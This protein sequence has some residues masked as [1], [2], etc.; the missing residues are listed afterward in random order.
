MSLPLSPRRARLLLKNASQVVTVGGG[1]KP[2]LGAAM[3][4]L[5]V[6][7]HHSLLVDHAGLVAQLVPGGAPTEAL[8][9]RLRQDEVRGEGGVARV[10]NCTGKVILPGF[11]DGHT[12][13]VGQSRHQV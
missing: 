6:L 5:S 9:A 4:Q 2:K 11:V 13:A 12:H 8:H 7:A 10:V 3:G 1:S